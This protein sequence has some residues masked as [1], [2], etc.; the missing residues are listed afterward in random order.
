MSLKL[1][2]ETGSALLIVM[3]LTIAIT[4]IGMMSAD[5]AAI[6]I[7]MSYNH[8]NDDQAFYVAD[9]GIKHGI[10]ELENDVTWRAGFVSQSLGNGVYVVTVTDSTTDSTLVDTVVLRSDAVVMEAVSVIQAYITKAPPIPIFQ[11]ALFA[12]DSLKMDQNS[13][14]DSYN[15]DSGTYAATVDTLDGD[16][17]SNGYIDLQG[18]STVGGGA[19]T[20]GDTIIIEGGSAV[21]GDTTSTADE[22]PMNLI[23]SSEFTWAEANSLA[24]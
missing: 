17:G 3:A 11:Y 5:R 7:T 23:P 4:L 21:M 16:I 19:S 2:Q 1:S 10:A 13:C 6:D 14:T 24:P 18:G 15:A 22:F 9:A 20:H 8:L 12:G